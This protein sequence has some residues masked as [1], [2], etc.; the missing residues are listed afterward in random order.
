[1][2]AEY[3]HLFKFYKKVKDY[4]IILFV[5]LLVLTIV[6]FFFAS[7]LAFLKNQ[8]TIL[9]ENFVKFKEALAQSQEKDKRMEFL[10]SENTRLKLDNEELKKNFIPQVNVNVLEAKNEFLKSQNTELNEKVAL[11]KTES[12]KAQARYESLAKENIA[13]N[14]ENTR[15]KTTRTSEDQ[16]QSNNNFLDSENMRLRAEIDTLR[17]QVRLL[18]ASV[19]KIYNDTSASSKEIKQ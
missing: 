7:R 18:E 16:L 13:L 9:S 17:N 12:A 10:F 19:L 5:S 4:E 14:D 1:M 8:N 11:L 6:L 2:L 15:L 3:K